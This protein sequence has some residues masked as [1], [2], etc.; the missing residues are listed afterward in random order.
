MLA[1]M[2]RASCGSFPCTAASWQGLKSAREFVSEQQQRHLLL[3]NPN[4]AEL[5]ASG[6]RG[7]FEDFWAR[8]M[9]QRRAGARARHG[10]GLADNGRAAHGILRDL[11]YYCD[12]APQAWRRC[13]DRPHARCMRFPCPHAGGS[14]RLAER[15]ACQACP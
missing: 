7:L 15:C 13:L 12:E 10:A 8:R 4:T 11:A 5:A 6:L 2:Q 14:W 3:H 1:C 9:Q